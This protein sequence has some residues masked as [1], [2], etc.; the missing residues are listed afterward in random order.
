MVSTTLLLYFSV[1]KLEARV[2][3]ASVA[4]KDTERMLLRL[5]IVL[6]LIFLVDAN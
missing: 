3:V 1:S 2:L 6:R 4:K 5:R